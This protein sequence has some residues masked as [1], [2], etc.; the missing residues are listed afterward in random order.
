M[1]RDAPAAVLI[2]L[3]VFLAPYNF[4]KIYEQ[5]DKDDKPQPF[6]DIGEP[7]VYNGKRG[8]L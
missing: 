4:S 6:R 2:F 7:G 1:R 8:T 3:C 5:P